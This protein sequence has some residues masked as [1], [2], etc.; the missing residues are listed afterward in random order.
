MEKNTIAYHPRARNRIA[1]FKMDIW[2]VRENNDFYQCNF[3]FYDLS[4]LRKMNVSRIS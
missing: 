1:P 4:N 2:I 3:S